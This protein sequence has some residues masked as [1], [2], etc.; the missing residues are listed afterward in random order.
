MV[1]T[2]I[3]RIKAWR[4]KGLSFV[5]AFKNFFKAKVIPRFTYAFALIQRKKLEVVRNLIEKTVEKALCNTF[6]WSIPKGAK[7]PSGTWTMVCGYPPVLALLRQLKLEMAARLKV[8]ENKAGRIFRKLYVSDR[9]SF[10]YDVQLALKEWLLLGQWERLTEGTVVAFKKRVRGVA[11]KC[12]PKG[13]QKNGR[14]SWLYH[15]HRIYSGNVPIWAD[16]KWP[17]RKDINAFKTH[18]CYLLTGLHPAG[19]KDARCFSVLCK[20]MNIGPV[21][22]HHFFECRNNYL[23]NRAYFRSR[24]RSMYDDY[25]AEG[26]I[27]IP[28]NVIDGI[29][30]KPCGMWVGLM[31]PGLFELGLNLKTVHETHKIFTIASVLSWGRFYSIPGGGTK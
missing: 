10:E 8:G 11:K 23:R 16:W 3:R 14:M 31:D 2:S 22:N 28:Q 4:T 18:F 29:L 20:S 7:I 12:W 1:E 9:G 17:K 27:N 15:I 6:G 25:V 26:H 19:G 30:E 21:Y 24:V 13:L 5:V